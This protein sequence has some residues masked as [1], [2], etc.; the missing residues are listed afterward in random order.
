MSAARGLCGLGAA[1]GRAGGHT[2]VEVDVEV[3]QLG[4]REHLDEARVFLVEAMA[5]EGELVLGELPVLPL[6]RFP[7]VGRHRIEESRGLPRLG[8]R[9]PRCLSCP[10]CWRGV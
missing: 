4:Q 3:A 5:Q 10:N 7:V 8:W 1:E 9:L 2:L 6:R